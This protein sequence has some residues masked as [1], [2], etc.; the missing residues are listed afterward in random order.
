MECTIFTTVRRIGVPQARIRD[1][2]HMVLGQL[3]HRDA[4]ISI[5]LVGDK[6]IRR[7]N[8]EYR[9]KDA[10]TDVLSFGMQEGEMPHQFMQGENV[11]WGDIFISVPKIRRQAKEYHVPFKEE[12][13]RMTIHGIL[14]LL[15]YDH[16]KEK[17][18]AAMFPLQD[19]FIVRA[20]KQF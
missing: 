12:L 8:R 15:G 1:V 11:D 5:H 18:A 20:L 7:L 3:K 13:Y 9:G 14:H 2:A 4:H 17:D 10:V 6:K 16:E 19:T